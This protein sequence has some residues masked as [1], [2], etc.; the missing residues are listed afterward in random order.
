MMKHEIL[1]G[2]SNVKV[3]QASPGCIELSRR[4]LTIRDLLE[5]S[6]TYLY[7]ILKPEA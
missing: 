5:P 6:E 1:D 2:K 3:E 4:L 7:V